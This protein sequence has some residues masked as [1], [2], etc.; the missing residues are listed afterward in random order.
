MKTPSAI[1]LRRGKPLANLAPR[2]PR[3]MRATRRAIAVRLSAN[4]AT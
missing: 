2:P 4:V 1:T 3:S